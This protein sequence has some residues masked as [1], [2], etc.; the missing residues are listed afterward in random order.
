MPVPDDRGHVIPRVGAGHLLARGEARD[1]EVGVDGGVL[2]EVARFEHAEPEAWRG[3]DRRFQHPVIV[4]FRRN[5][6]PFVLRGGK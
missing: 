4:H 2:L 5:N 6:L 1:F 3:E